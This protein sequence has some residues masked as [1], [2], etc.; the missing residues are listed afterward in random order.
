[1]SCILTGPRDIAHA[2]NTYTRSLISLHSRGGL[3]PAVLGVG[4]IPYRAMTGATHG[5]SLPPLGRRDPARI[6]ARDNV[7][8]WGEWHVVAAVACTAQ[9]HCLGLP[10]L[11]MP[12][13]LPYQGMRDLMQERVVNVRVWSRAGIRM[14]EGD[15]LRLIVTAYATTGGSLLHATS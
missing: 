6:R 3:L 15:N 8:R 5:A 11:I 14:G 4:R 12:V 2:A 13:G 9:R 7:A 1:M 10:D